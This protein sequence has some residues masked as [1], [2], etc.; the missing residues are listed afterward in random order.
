MNKEIKEA[1]I[2]DEGRLI[3]NYLKESLD[4]ELDA[5][6]IKINGLS[7]EQIGQQ[8]RATLEAREFLLKKINV[9]TEIEKPKAPTNIFK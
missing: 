9:L 4:K 3:I 7:N 5:N 6:K 8:T 1:A 2:S